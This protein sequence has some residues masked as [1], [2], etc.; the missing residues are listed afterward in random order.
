MSRF[1]SRLV[2]RLS[3]FLAPRR[4]LP[5]MIGIALV[6]LNYVLQFVPGLEAFARTNTLLHAGILLGLLGLLLAQAL[7]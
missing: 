6:V 7:G 1:F 2:D 4:G 5:T 3:E